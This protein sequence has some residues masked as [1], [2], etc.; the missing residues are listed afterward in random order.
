MDKKC[1]DLGEFVYKLS[2]DRSI[3]RISDAVEIKIIYVISEKYF[4]L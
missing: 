1:T 2:S 4:L 3:K